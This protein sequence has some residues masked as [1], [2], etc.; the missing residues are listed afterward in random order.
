MCMESVR[1]PSI[2]A[3]LTA[4]SLIEYASAVR[5]HYA[6]LLLTNIQ[7]VRDI[8]TVWQEQRQRNMCLRVHGVHV[9]QGSRSTCSQSPGGRVVDLDIFDKFR[10]IYF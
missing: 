3:V 2:G 9:P 6:I 8:G 5:Y 1:G 7:Q 10:G 4:R